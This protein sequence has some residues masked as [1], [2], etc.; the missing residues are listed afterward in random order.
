LGHFARVAN[1]ANQFAADGLFVERDA[2]REPAFELV[3]GGAGQAVNDHAMS[4]NLSNEGQNGDNYRLSQA[5]AQPSAESNTS[6]AIMVARF[7]SALQGAPRFCPS[8]ASAAFTV[9]SPIREAVQRS[10]S[11]SLTRETAIF[12]C[13]QACAIASR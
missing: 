5:A 4:L 7:S 1:G 6:Q 11:R 10:T 8:A 13:A 3:A 2:R 12:S 9:F